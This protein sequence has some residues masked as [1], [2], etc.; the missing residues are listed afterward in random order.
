MRR[1]W[2]A[3]MADGRYKQAQEYEMIADQARRNA[4]SLRQLLQVGVVPNT[5]SKGT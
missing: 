3:A 2:E 5:P 1:Q 4:H